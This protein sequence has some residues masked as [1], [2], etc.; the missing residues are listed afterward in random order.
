MKPTVVTKYER[1]LEVEF[2]NRYVFYLPYEFIRDSCP[3]NFDKRH[4]DRV[5]SI[6]SV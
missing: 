5:F 2:N 6:S 1:S 4:G 3:T